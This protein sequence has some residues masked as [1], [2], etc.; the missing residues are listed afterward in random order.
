MSE[1]KLSPEDLRRR[2]IAFLIAAVDE[3]KEDLISQLDANPLVFLTGTL[4]LT[5]QNGMIKTAKPG[6]QK[7]RHATAV[8]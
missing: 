1:Q 2:N 6:I 3:F 4:E 7:C 8:A 5:V